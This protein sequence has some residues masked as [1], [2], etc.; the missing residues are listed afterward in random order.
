MPTNKQKLDTERRRLE[1]VALCRRCKVEKD[2]SEF[3]PV[4]SRRPFGLRDVCKPCYAADERARE[5][6]NTLVRYGLTKETYKLLHD[7]QNGLCAICG[8]PETT[9]SSHGNL[10]K[11]SVDHDHATGKVRG[12]LCRSCNLALGKFNDSTSVL[13]SAIAYLEKNNSHDSTRRTGCDK[14]EHEGWRE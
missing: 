10:H 1:H 4:P 12:L 9:E 2:W 13:A 6:Q 14:G 11:L 8:R 3:T 7:K 5:R